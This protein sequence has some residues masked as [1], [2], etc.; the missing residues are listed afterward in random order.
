MAFTRNP[1]DTD[2][3]PA[4]YTADG[5]SELLLLDQRRDIAI[6]GSDDDD[7]VSVSADAL[8]SSALYDYNVRGFEGD[9]TITFDARLI[10]N[11]VINGNVGDDTME[12]GLDVATTA[13][14]GS[15]FL[16]GKGNDTLTAED[17]SYGEINGNIG[18]D[19]II[20]DNSFSQQGINQYVGGGQGNDI[21]TVT[22]S[23]TN[24][25]IDGNKGDDTL[26]VE[27]GDHTGTSINGGEGNDVL[28]NL[29]GF[30]T[31]GLMMNGDAGNDTIISIGTAG[32][33]VTGGEG[34]DTIVAAAGAGE[35]SSID[36]GVGAD[37]VNILGSLGD[38]VVIF[39]SGD[40]VAATASDLG[41][42]PFA[43]INGSITFGSGVD[44]I[45]GFTSGTDQIDTDLNTGLIFGVDGNIALNTD[46]LGV[47]S[48]T[49]VQGTLTGN[50]FETD[51]LGTDFLYV[52]GGENLTL[53]QVF[54]N[55]DNIFVSVGAELAI[56]DFV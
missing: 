13:F 22:G 47:N 50:V 45:T 30:T 8:S 12:L 11:S 42:A 9:D 35:D 43:P 56:A 49:Q 25:I 4:T 18:N 10:Q 38:E 39:D 48:I 7:T 16:G 21:V 26:V 19:F 41:N 33:T 40:S 34:Q 28:R 1:S 51:V 3:S 52:V 20:I 37:D 14:E 55:S 24:S 23:F 29:A 54:T 15:Y 6:D 17:V 32:S 27:D 31:E 5:S 2:V 46:T 36:A 44:L 53:G